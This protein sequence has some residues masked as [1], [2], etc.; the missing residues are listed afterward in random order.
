MGDAHMLVSDGKEPGFP[1]S[2]TKSYTI[3]DS[4][5][6]PFDPL[7]MKNAY[8]RSPDHYASQQRL[9]KQLKLEKDRDVIALKERLDK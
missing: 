1:S 5:H 4:Q 2:R 7:A 3:V 9:D 6:I 8:L